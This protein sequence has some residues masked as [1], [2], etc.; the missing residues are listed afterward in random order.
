MKGFFYTNVQL[1]HK[2]IYVRGYKDG[3]YF[4]DIVHYKP[5]IF[6]PSNEDTGW[7][8]LKGESL[9]PVVMRDIQSMT[10]YVDGAR[11]SMSIHGFCEQNEQVYAYIN[12]LIPDEVKYDSSLIRTLFFDIE[13]ETEGGYGRAWDDPFQKI[14]CITIWIKDLG[15]IVWVLTTHMIQS[16]KTLSIGCST[17]RRSSS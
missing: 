3:E 17:M 15:Y 12:E 8:S 13:T 9:K 5:T 7:R 10:D 11:G 1:I 6:L 4:S 2:K 14:N 16:L